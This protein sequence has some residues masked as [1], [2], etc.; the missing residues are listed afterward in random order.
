MLRTVEIIGGGLAGL[1]SGIG[2]RARGV[3]VRIYEA[4]TYPRHRVCGEFIAGLDDRT[5]AELQLD[6]FLQSARRASGVAWFAP[7][8]TAMRH[9]LPRPA[10]CLSRFRLDA[11]MAEAFR[12]AG[13]DLRTGQRLPAEPAEGRVMACGRRPLASSPWIGLKQHFRGLRLVDDLEVHLGHRAYVGVTRV[14]GAVVNVCGLFPRPETGRSAALADRVRAVGLPDLAER[15]ASAD[16]VGGSECAVAGLDYAARAR[17]PAALGDHGGLIPPFTGHGMTIALQGAAAT[18]DHFEAWSK[19]VRDWPETLTR[20][21]RTLRQRF[22]RRLFVA[23]LMH[24]WLLHRRPR[25]F[26]RALHRCG[27]LP[28][29]LLYRL[30][31]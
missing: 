20:V 28:F 19:G 5:R 2:L 8:G 13:G 16:P 22:R 1:S 11:G 14:E 15:L 17:L 31:H 25:Q 23:R 3:P 18:L 21:S 10:F 12:A 4:G 29:G 6:A 30:S 24:P 27:V 9:R 26:A 7:D